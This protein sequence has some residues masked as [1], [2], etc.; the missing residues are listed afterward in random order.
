[1]SALVSLIG[2]YL[3]AMCI[4]RAKENRPALAFAGGAWAL[5]TAYAIWGRVQQEFNT[6]IMLE[7][8]LISVSFA[9]LSLLGLTFGKWLATRQ[10]R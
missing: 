7:I 3:F 2:G 10:T 5:G 4:M 1:M 9:G 8:L 6:D